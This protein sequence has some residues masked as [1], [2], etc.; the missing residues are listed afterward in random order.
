M[1]ASPPTLNETSCFLPQIRSFPKSKE[2]LE[3][4]S[5]S[6]REGGYYLHSVDKHRDYEDAPETRKNYHS[7]TE[8]SN[9]IHVSKTN[10][11]VRSPWCLP[12][13]MV[14]TT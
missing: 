13:L 2:K 7:A 9:G 3:R 8:V 12:V 1:L 5:L 6:L 14:T 11:I 10:C 4:L